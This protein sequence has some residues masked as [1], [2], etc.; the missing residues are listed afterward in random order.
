[1]KYGNSNLHV[2]RSGL[3]ARTIGSVRG[4]T[5]AVD[6][7]W[8]RRLI[9]ARAEVQDAH[10]NGTLSHGEW[11]RGGPEPAPIG[12]GPFT[13]VGEP[14]AVAAVCLGLP[15]DA[16][17]TRL[18]LEDLDAGLPAEAICV[19]GVAG[20][21]SSADP[22]SADLRFGPFGGVARGLRRAVLSE[23]A[24]QEVESE[25]ALSATWCAD[26]STDQS[27]LLAHGLVAAAYAGTRAVIV[28]DR[29]MAAVGQWWAR[30]LTAITCKAAESSGALVN[31]GIAAT[32]APLGDEAVLQAVG[33]W[34]PASLVILLTS[35]QSN[36]NAR[37]L[38]DSTRS[39]V[40]RAGRPVLE[41]SVR[42]ATP[43]AQLG[44]AWLGLEA[45]LTVAVAIGVPPLAMEPGE[46]LRDTL[47][48]SGGPTP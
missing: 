48:S 47:L 20:D 38:A 30:C 46:R 21:A 6:T 25:L 35:G 31:R 40:T 22:A 42:Q 29:S 4:L 24:N 1:M 39:V 11:I 15:P 2:D 17:V 8:R 37:R 3:L 7:T 9:A 23:E 13:V 44:F 43:S 32:W 16:P 41:V 36:H 45:A 18:G 34:D 14:G 33:E 27:L 28:T 12:N 10:S 19:D 26:L 5:A